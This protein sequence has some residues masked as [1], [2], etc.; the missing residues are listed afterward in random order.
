M[1]KKK[2]G[3]QRP[4][5]RKKKAEDKLMVDANADDLIILVIGATGAGK[6]KF[7]NDYLRTT[8]AQ[9]GDEHELKLCTRHIDW[10]PTRLPSESCYA[11]RRLILVDTPGFDN[12]EIDDGEILRRIELWLAA[13]YSNGTS[14]TGVLYLHD[15]TQKRIRGPTSL[16]LVE[17]LVGTGSL[18][19]LSFITTQWDTDTVQVGEERENELRDTFWKD[20]LNG[21]ATISRVHK[22]LEHPTPHFDVVENIL[23]R[24]MGRQSEDSADGNESRNSEPVGWI[25]TIKNQVI[26]LFFKL[27]MKSKASWWLR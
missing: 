2:S 14:L 26:A 16:K 10:Y 13:S 3:R 17:R 21:G 15:I 22:T 5:Q 1:S 4:K 18:S 7:I 27:A 12:D 19:T 24:H 9:V 8:V 6:S 25:E 11:G 20:A 23:R